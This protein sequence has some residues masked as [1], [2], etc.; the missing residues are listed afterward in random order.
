MS[1]EQNDIAMDRDEADRRKGSGLSRRKFN[2]PEVKEMFG[3]FGVEDPRAGDRRTS[4]DRRDEKSVSDMVEDSEKS[5]GY[6][7]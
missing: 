3:D 6:I 2:D 4:T 1:D 5:P 7:E